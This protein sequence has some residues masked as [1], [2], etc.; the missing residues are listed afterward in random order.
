MKSLGIGLLVIL[1]V[2]QVQAGFEIDKNIYRMD[3]LEEAKAEAV[4]DNKPVTFVYTDAKTTCGLC[5]SSSLCSINELKGKSVLVYV[6]SKTD[7]S[8][9]PRIVQDAIKDPKM[10]KYIPKVVIATPEVDSVIASIPYSLGSEQSKHLKDAK[11][12]IAKAMP[13][14]SNT[15]KPLSSPTKTA[16]ATIQPDENRE[17][18]MWKAKTG[19]EIKASLVKESGS[20]LMLKKEDGSTLRVMLSKLVQEDHDYVASI[21][22]KTE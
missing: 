7:W 15:L 11:R 14:N 9:T 5:T 20:Y 10:G 3:Q 16:V 21:K 6:D 1:M 8:I 19:A 4:E 18:R 12:A 2:L 13:K 17:M 22:A